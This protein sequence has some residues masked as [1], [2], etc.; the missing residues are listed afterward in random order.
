M[1]RRDIC[2]TPAGEYMREFQRDASKGKDLQRQAKGGH[3]R[4][5]GR[6]QMR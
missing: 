1:Y 6:G 3:E 5:V 2:K 4:V